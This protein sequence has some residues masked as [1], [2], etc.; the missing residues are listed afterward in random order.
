MLD[1]KAPQT[2][3]QV[4]EDV[5]AGEN[6]KTAT[7]KRAKQSKVKWPLFITNLKNARNRN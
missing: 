7:K 2:G 4:A 6:V 3:V 5:L 1:K